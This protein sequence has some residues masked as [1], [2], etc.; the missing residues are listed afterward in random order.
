VNSPIALSAA[1]SSASPTD[2][3]RSLQAFANYPNLKMSTD[4]PVKSIKVNNVGAA[5]SGNSPNQGRER[6]APD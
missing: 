4:W 1:S 6:P 3:P 5:A 2:S